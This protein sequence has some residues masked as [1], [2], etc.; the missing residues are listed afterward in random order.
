MTTTTK[1]LTTE[2]VKSRHYDPVSW[3]MWYA[4]PMVDLVTELEAECASRG[5]TLSRWQ[6]NRGS[7]AVSITYAIH[8]G[9]RAH[10]FRYQLDATTATSPLWR[11]QR[12]AVR[13]TGRSAGC[14]PI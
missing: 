7:K 13:R 9:E 6:T 1:S 10:Q 8:T 4:S 3:Q 12:P 11:A 5:L 2:L 14:W